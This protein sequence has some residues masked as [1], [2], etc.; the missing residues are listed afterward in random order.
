MSERLLQLEPPSK[1][2]TSSALLPLLST[3]LQRYRVQQE[4][5]F[6]EGAD[7][8]A[9]VNERAQFF[10]QLLT[11][12]W[13]QI[14]FDEQFSLIAIG[15]YG[16]GELHPHSDIDLLILHNNDSD[17]IY[18]DAIET[19]LQLLWDLRL[20]VGHSVRT[21]SQCVEEA[22]KDI[23]VATSLMEVRTIVGDDRDRQ[24]LL[25][26]IAP[27][28]IWSAA[29]F[30][31]AKQNEQSARHQRHGI[32][33][34]DLEPNVKKSPGGLRDIQTLMWV[35]KR[36]YKVDNRDQLRNKALFSDR[37]F[38]QLQQGEE[39]LWR[40]RFGLHTL[41]GR[42]QEVLHFDL[43]RQLAEQFG[44]QDNERL[45]VEQFMQDYYRTVMQLRLVN[46]VVMRHLQETIVDGEDQKTITPINQHFQMRGKLLETTHK[47]VFSEYPSGL[48][49]I[50]LHW[51]AGDAKGIRPT[52]IRQIQAHCHLI[53]DNFRCQ[54]NNQRLF[55]E[56]FR[57]PHRLSTA[58]QRMTRYGVLGNYLP[59]FGQIIGQMQHDLFH[60][61]PVDVHTL[62]VV[63][64]IRR[65]G[66]SKAAK[67][68][69][70]AAE[71]YQR[72]EGK[73]WLLI[74]ALYHD[75]GKGRGGNHSLLGAVDMREFGLQHRLPEDIT[76]MMVWLVE[77]HLLMSRTSQKEDISDPE[78]INKFA[79]RVKN[80]RYLDAL[81]VL[82]VA[83]VNATNPDLWNSW[84][85]SL[86]NQ[87]YHEASQAL[88][89]GSED[90]LNQSQRIEDNRRLAL[91][92]L[93]GKVDNKQVQTLW[94]N[95]GDDYFLRENAD[96]IAWHTEAIA[97][98][99]NQQPMVLIKSVA[100]TAAEGVT[101]IFI[102][103]KDQDNSFAAMAAALD[104][105]G[106]NIQGAQ[107]Y[108]SA[109]GYTLDTFYVLD[110]N[111]QPITTDPQHYRTIR[112]AIV[113]ELQL[114][115]R[116]SDIVSRRTSRR[117]KQFP[118]ATTTQLSQHS[119][120]DYSILEVTT[121]DRSG[122]LALIGRIFV[123][124]GIRVQN[125]KISTL[126]ERVEDLFYISDR[127]NQPITDP[128]LGENLQQAIR[129]RIDSQI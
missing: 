60:I 120:G 96:D 39:L 31:I 93:D 36:Y 94:E 101:Q 40:V 61:Y 6:Q 14:G 66:R 27:D 16:R 87:L 127:D 34:Y 10:D 3:E 112:N 55:L 1:S 91:Q 12:I 64:N 74:T 72:T 76:E 19:F 11:L 17:S 92:K 65:L 54:E 97:Q 45:A 38:S 124:F 79:N 114:L 126:G 109:D 62:Q 9:L 32:N 4:Q 121:A 104:Q 99:D 15:G 108:N 46:E 84:K 37:E 100:S 77:N 123:E 23:A 95:L 117:L 41:S 128:K 115:D 75:I 28:K 33:E 58:L 8:R 56:L 68:F 118:V 107:L 106:L 50:F 90:T 129:Q 49:E 111:D 116:Y 88:A 5:Q 69:P 44:Y 47:R 78:V 110:N 53:D 35:A 26:A 22:R 113:H 125:A 13:Q 25:E 71:L 122:L 85:A 29:D 30:F 80:Q 2:L 98:Y 21:L 67:L 73:E 7:I 43:Q 57:Q 24:T 18:K 52:T 59:E 82:T 86:M 105:L 81:Y 83:D 51:M 70:L 20:N 119:S 42:P 102:R 89:R 48:L 63:K 103:L